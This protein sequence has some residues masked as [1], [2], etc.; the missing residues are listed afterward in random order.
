MST[1]RIPGRQFF[2]VDFQNNGILFQFILS[3]FL[4]VAKTFQSID[5]QSTK[6]KDLVER[7]EAPTKRCIRRLLESFTDLTGDHEDF[8]PLFP[9]NNQT[10]SLSTFYH[11][12]CILCRKKS[13]DQNATKLANNAERYYRQALQAYN[14]LVDMEKEEEE[15]RIALSQPLVNTI[16]AC[17]RSMGRISRLIALWITVFYKNENVLLF[18]LLH[19]EEFD[20][21]YKAPIT[22]QLFQ[23]MFPEGLKQGEQFLLRRY[24]KRGFSNLLPLISDKLNALQEI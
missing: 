9:W 8:I 21:M 23:K 10:G 16:K 17:E 12:T 22:Q 5:S 18:L 4:K 1:T 14:Y 24:G 2:T 19:H 3:Q 7:S 20:A 15:R 6:I 13:H 11:Y